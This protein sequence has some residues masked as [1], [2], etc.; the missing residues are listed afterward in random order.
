[1]DIVKFIASVLVGIIWGVIWGKIFSDIPK[2]VFNKIL[3]WLGLLLP[4]TL[5]SVFLLFVI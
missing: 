3:F 2:G 5:S 1:M 4:P